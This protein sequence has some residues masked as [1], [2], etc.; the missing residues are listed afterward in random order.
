MSL[1]ICAVGLRRMDR[2]A[3]RLGT[4][5]VHHNQHHLERSDLAA[6]SD[7]DVKYRVMVFDHP[8]LALRSLRNDGL[9]STGCDSVY[10]VW[11][12]VCGKRSIGDGSVI[13]VRNVCPVACSYVE[14]VGDLDHYKM[15][16]SGFQ[17]K[18]R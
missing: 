12:V 13:E 16:S 3:D 17:Q 2:A 9:G 11:V 15:V 18:A 5:R 8:S 1:L 4:Q 10:S 6:L 14:L 7:V